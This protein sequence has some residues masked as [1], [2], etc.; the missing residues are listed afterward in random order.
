MWAHTTTWIVYWLKKAFKLLLNS[1]DSMFLYAKKVMNLIDRHKFIRRGREWRKIGKQKK[2]NTK[3]TKID[4]YNYLR[5]GRPPNNLYLSD[6]AW[7][8]A[9]KPLVATFSAYNSTESS[10]KL[11]RFWTTE[12]NSRMR[13]PFS[14]KTC[15]VFV[16]KMMISVRVGVTLTSTPL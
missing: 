4:L 9:H 14:P 1:I 6:S 8:T 3:L 13:L 15:W 10:S 16:A 11:K 5:T 12:V 2:K 7:A